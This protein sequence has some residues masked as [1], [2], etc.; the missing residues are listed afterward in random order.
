MTVL[1]KCCG[2]FKFLSNLVWVMA[3]S[4]PIGSVFVNSWPVGSVWTQWT[5]LITLMLEKALNMMM[6]TSEQSKIP[7]T[8]RHL[9]GERNTQQCREIVYVAICTGIGA[10]NP[11][12]TTF[13]RPFGHFTLVHWS[14]CTL[15]GWCRTVPQSVQMSVPSVKRYV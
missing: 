11:I 8:F 13:L 9:L 1:S 4:A 15:M 5:T 3:Q 10:L 2:I 12:S 14:V 6:R 7:T